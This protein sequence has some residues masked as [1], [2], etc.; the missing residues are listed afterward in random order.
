METCYYLG[1]RRLHNPISWAPP[2]LDGDEGMCM[3]FRVVLSVADSWRL[4]V[5]SSLCRLCRLSVFLVWNE[6]LFL[7]ANAK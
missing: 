6:A 1:P 7:V 3:P 2:R 5:V 4:L